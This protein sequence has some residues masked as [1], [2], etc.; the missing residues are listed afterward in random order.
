MD[1]ADALQ[2][3]NRVEAA[4][5][6]LAPSTALL[7][8]PDPTAQGLTPEVAKKVGLWMVGQSASDSD[9]RL[10]NV[11][12]PI[13]GLEKPRELARLLAF[14]P[15]APIVFDAIYDN[16]DAEYLDASLVERLLPPADKKI[17]SNSKN[18]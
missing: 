15:D 7:T 13:V 6:R 8:V 18:E 9:G 1:L 12:K 2:I 16:H 17:E 14:S 3:V 11:H 5:L 4:N 10:W